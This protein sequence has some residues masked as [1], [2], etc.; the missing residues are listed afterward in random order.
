MTGW[1]LVIAVLTAQAILAAASLALVHRAMRSA[2]GEL[3]LAIDRLEASLD[4]L[5]KRVTELRRRVDPP[6]L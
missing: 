3:H 5:G 1:P 6:D 4:Q 2:F